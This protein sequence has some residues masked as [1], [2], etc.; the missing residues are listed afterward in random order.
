M[1]ALQYTQQYT[2][3]E[4]FQAA[5]RPGG[6]RRPGGSMVAHLT[7]MQQS[8]VLIQPLPRQPK[9][10]GVAGK[11]IIYFKLDMRES[12]WYELV[13]RNELIGVLITP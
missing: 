7:V 11:N 2:R 12:C 6:F 3:G 9:I 5:R 1:E 13:L 8:R 10:L 4:G